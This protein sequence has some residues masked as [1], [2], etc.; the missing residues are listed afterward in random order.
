MT[1]GREALL[2]QGPRGRRLAYD[3]AS[4]AADP[5]GRQ[6]LWMWHFT[7]EY[8]HRLADRATELGS[9]SLD[10]IREL[11]PM[12]VHEALRASVDAA[13]Y[14]QPPDEIDQLC[15]ALGPE[16]FLPILS[17]AL[18]NPATDWWSTGLQSGHQ[19]YVQ[20]HNRHVESKYNPEPAD[21]ELSID[22][23]ERWRNDEIAT[24]GRR[25][26]DKHHSD[27]HSNM[28]G[29]WWSSPHPRWI[30]SRALPGLGCAGLHYIEDRG[31]WPEARLWNIE[32]TT[33][34][35]VYEISSPEDWAA[36]VDEYPLELTAS[37]RHDWFRVTGVDSRWFV[38]DYRRVAVEYDALHLT[39]DGYLATAGRAVP[40]QAGSSVMAGFAPDDTF[41]FNRDGLRIRADTRWHDE[42]DGQGDWVP[43]DSPPPEPST[44]A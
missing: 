30:T 22:V 32:I 36:L 13:M 27:L 41:W 9:V 5:T 26:A 44:A 37:Y 31:G 34:Q 6:S 19:M 40:V 8:G 20:W 35:R 15:A 38:P 16:P 33:P 39:V 1:S 4:L 25:A 43:A 3:W 12:H 29:R 14:W 23:W 2:A 10:A 42:G 24:E 28:S 11:D 7:P 17:A 21:V 18:D